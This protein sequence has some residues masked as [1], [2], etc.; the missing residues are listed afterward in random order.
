MKPALL[1]FALVSTLALVATAK[2][3]RYQV[4]SD[5]ATGVIIGV[6]D[7]DPEP[8]P[9]QRKRTVTRADYEAHLAARPAAG[10]LLD[11]PT[12]GL[13]AARA[14]EIAAH[15]DKRGAAI[16]DRLA[17]GTLTSDEQRQLLARLLARIRELERAAGRRD[18]AAAPEPK[19]A[20]PR[21]AK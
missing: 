10:V 1:A 6:Y 3:R 19:P 14:A 13:R 5:A 2:D 20:P 15:D 8:L 9:G 16:E 18:D 4:I 17:A 11:H 21:P 12:E 7:H